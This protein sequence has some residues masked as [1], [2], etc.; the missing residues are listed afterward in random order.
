MSQLHLTFCLLFCTRVSKEVAAVLSLLCRPF[1]VEAV[2][3]RPKDIVVIVDK[4]GS[5]GTAYHNGRTLMQIAKEAAQTVIDTAGPDDRVSQIHYW[6]KVG[7]A[8][9][10]ICIQ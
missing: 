5:M 4:S 10:C 3:P 2:T 8:L 7:A 9:W 6:S 1:Y